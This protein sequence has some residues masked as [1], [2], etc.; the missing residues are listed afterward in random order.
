MLMDNRWRGF[1]ES[2]MATLN[3]AG[4]DGRAVCEVPAHD[5]RGCGGNT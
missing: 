1:N 2:A 5:G 4:Q 3:D